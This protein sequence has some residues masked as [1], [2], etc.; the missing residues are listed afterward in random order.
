MKL[1]DGLWTHHANFMDAYLEGHRQV[2]AWSCSE[3]V[4]S[5]V[6]LEVG[7]IPHEHSAWPW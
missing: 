4:S 5:S 2:Y 6:K 7:G 3:L 1:G